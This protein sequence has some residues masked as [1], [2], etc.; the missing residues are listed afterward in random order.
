[1]LFSAPW[2]RI[3]RREFIERIGAKFQETRHSN[4]NLWHISVMAKAMRITHVRQTF[5]T[6]RKN[7]ACSVQKVKNNGGSLDDTLLAWKKSLEFVDKCK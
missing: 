6:Y 7:T 2:N 1:M 5:Y 4:D 3:Y